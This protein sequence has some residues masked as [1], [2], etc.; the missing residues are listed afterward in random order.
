M[1][2]P[3]FDD[4]KTF[5]VN[6]SLTNHFP[7]LCHNIPYISGCG[8]RKASLLLC[9]YKKDMMINDGS[10]TF[11]ETPVVIMSSENV[12]PRITRF[13][14]SE[15]KRLK[16][17]LRIRDFHQEIVIDNHQ[18]VHDQNDDDLQSSPSSCLTSSDSPSKR[19]RNTMNDSDCFK[20][21]HYYEF[22]VF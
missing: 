1:Y 5:H 14:L 10:K 13:K 22:F 12:L 18:I 21:L 19:Q 16:N 4:I 11:K 8:E 7:Q 15:V 2:V 3:M 17:N 20:V 6:N 9:L